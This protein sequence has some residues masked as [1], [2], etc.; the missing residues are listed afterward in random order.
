MLYVCAYKRHFK[1]GLSFFI[2]SFTNR[3]FEKPKN[4]AEVTQLENGSTRVCTQVSVSLRHALSRFHTKKAL[5][6]E[7]A[8]YKIH[9]YLLLTELP[10]QFPY[11]WNQENSTYHIDHSENEM[12]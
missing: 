7:G 8:C 11:L 3:D 12:S 5:P 9:L 1:A 10:N 6:L 2:S 4:F